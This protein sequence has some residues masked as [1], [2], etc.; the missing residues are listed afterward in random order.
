MTNKAETLYIF[1]SRLKELR[2]EHDMTQRQLAQNLGVSR[3]CVANWEKKLRFPKGD[4]VAKMARM[5]GVS[6][7]YLC[8]RTDLRYHIKKPQTREMDFSVLNA[9][10]NDLVYEF[11]NFVKSKEKYRA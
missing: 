2:E 8:G 7:D 4:I 3:S 6:A 10:G 9:L 5:F 1:S 11:F